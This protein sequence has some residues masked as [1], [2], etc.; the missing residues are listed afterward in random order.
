MT[1]PLFLVPAGTLA[2]SAG[3]EVVVTGPEARHA[4]SAMRMRPGERVLLGDGAGTK[5]EASVVHAAGERLAAH[6]D[7]VCQ[8]PPP[9]PRFV[10]VQA[11]AKGDR[12][13]SAVE[14]AVEL[15]VDEVIPWQ[16][17]RCVV[18]WRDDRAERGRRK[19]EATVLAAT[20]QSRRAWLPAVG[21]VVDTGG[22]TERV[23]ASGLTLVLH[24]ESVGPLAA[25]ELPSA[26]DVLVVV[27]PEGG[28]DEREL[29]ALTGAGAHPVR[30]GPEVLRSSTAGPAALAVLNA[31]SRWL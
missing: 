19:W 18:R 7:S 30:L 27:G 13:L 28:I 23:A 31:R 14:A 11:L 2:V 21:S 17:H 12:D 26:G 3:D 9:S 4:V 25:V 16:A 22:L 5:V 20:K 6:V 10:L 29:A 8:V 15:G 24:E 1:L